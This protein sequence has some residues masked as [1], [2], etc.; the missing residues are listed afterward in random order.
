MNNLTKQIL[1]FALLSLASFNQGVALPAELEL[2]SVATGMTLATVAGEFTP[3]IHA[4]GQDLSEVPLA[5]RGNLSELRLRYIGLETQVVDISMPTTAAVPE[6][7]SVSVGPET[8]NLNNLEQFMQYW[9]QLLPGIQIL[10]SAY[11][12]QFC[13]QGHYDTVL[14]PMVLS[15][16][17]ENQ[18]ANMT[19]AVGQSLSQM[20]P[21]AEASTEYPYKNPMRKLGCF[22]AMIVVKTLTRYENDPDAPEWLLRAYTNLNR[23][24]REYGLYDIIEQIRADAQEGHHRL[25]VAHENGGREILGEAAIQNMFGQIC[26]IILCHVCLRAYEL[27]DD[28]AILDQ[29]FI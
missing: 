13:H 4:N 14:D 16:N 29:L 3:T 1:G 12:I 9:R 2:H 18:L 28:T 22:L 7:L 25:N 26:E 10:E 23:L 21:E 15:S 24:P 17:I 19:A 5:V 20:D 27:G 6:Y 11:Q 8:P